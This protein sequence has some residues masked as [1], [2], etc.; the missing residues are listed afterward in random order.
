[1][2]TNPELAFVQVS[3]LKYTPKNTHSLPRTLFLLQADLRIAL[4]Y[5]YGYLFL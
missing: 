3:D 1:M 4:D 2:N 5:L